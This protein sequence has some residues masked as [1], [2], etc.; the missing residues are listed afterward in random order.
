LPGGTGSCA[1]GITNGLDNDRNEAGW[2]M[3]LEYRLDAV[4]T[5]GF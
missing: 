4:S 3:Y 2:W 5:S 1:S